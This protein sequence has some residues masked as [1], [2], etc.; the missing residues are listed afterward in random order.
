L[1]ALTTLIASLVM[2]SAPAGSVPVTGGVLGGFEQDGNQTFEGTA[3]GAT[4]DW[5]TLSFD[6][7][8]P[9]VIAVDD[10]LDSG[11]TEGS[12]ELQ[13]SGWAC[14]NGGADPA[15]SDILRAFANPRVG[16][17]I[18]L[19]I[20]FIRK[21]GEDSNGRGDVHVNFEFNQA[22]ADATKCP[23]VRQEGDLLVT[24]DFPGGADAPNIMAWRWDESGGKGQDEGDWDDVGLSASQAK[25]AVNLDAMVDQVG[26][27]S[28]DPLG[29]IGAQRFGEATL[30]LTQALEPEAGAPACISFGSLNVRSRSSGES[31][32]SSLQ[33]KLAP[34]PI[35]FSTCGSIDL[36]KKGNGGELLAGAKFQLWLSADNTFGGDTKVGPVCTT[37]AQGVCDWDDLNPGKYF[38]EETAAPDGYSLDADPVVGPINLG[39]RQTISLDDFVNFK[40]L[41]RLNLSPDATNLVKTDHVFTATLEVKKTA[42]GSYGPAAGETLGIDLSGAV[43]SIVSP[44]TTC[45][46]NAAGQCAITIHSDNP[47]DSFLEVTFDDKVTTIAVD[48][49]DEAV[50]HWV[51]YSIDI[52]PDATNQVGKTH[53]FTVTLK[54]DSGSGPVPVSGA[55]P[56]VTKVSGPGNFSDDS[57]ALAGTNA[58]GQCTVKLTSDVVGTTVVKATYEAVEEA[59]K[60]TF[61][62]TATKHWVD[63]D[64][65]VR[66]NGVNHVGDD[67]EFTVRLTE[68]VNSEP[69][70][71][72]GETVSLD[73]DGPVGS[74]IS[75]AASCET[76]GNGECDVVASSDVTGSGTLTA[77]W[78]REV[79][80]GVITLSDSA[81]KTWIDWDISIA[82]DDK[83]NL[84][85]TDH[86][87][88]VKVR[89]DAGDGEG[90]QPLAGATPDIAIDG[91]GTVKDTDCDEGTDSNG[92]CTATITSAQAGD[93][94]VTATWEAMHASSGVSEDLSASAVKHWVD[95]RIDVQ[96]DAV[97]LVGDN[98]VFTV[99]VT[100]DTGDGFAPLADAD[101][102]L[103]WSGGAGSSITSAV[104]AGATSNAC[105]TDDAGQCK[106]TVKSGTPLT[107]T[108][109]ATY[110][111]VLDSG[112][113]SFSA[114][115]QKRWVNWTLSI[116]PA[117]AEN[118]VGTNHTFVVKVSR[119]DG[120][121][122]GLLPLAG[123][124]PVITL[125]GKG[126]I[127]ANTCS[128]G[129]SA[130]G[131]CT[132]TITSSE[133][134]T[135]TV[136]AAFSATED[137]ASISLSGSGQKL[138]VDYRIAV[139]PKTAVNPVNTTHTFTVTLEKNIGNGWVVA[140]SEKLNL[141]LTGVGSIIGVDLGA[142]GSALAGTCT[143]DAAGT[144]RVTI[145]SPVAGLATLQASYG[146]TVG[147]T[148][149][150]FTDDGAKT[151]EVP[152]VV[153]GAQEL[154]RT[155]NPMLPLLLMAGS[156]LTLAGQAVNAGRRRLLRRV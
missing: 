47:G 17:N 51:D 83:T 125:A 141:G 43:G 86:E 10:T 93:S 153:L 12:K 102:S 117:Q 80:S 129:T 59:T 140:G 34:T 104:P 2:L 123:A 156:S 134:G 120:K 53:T 128:E 45:T 30:D 44:G 65:T 101:V 84:V 37:N 66:P 16:D 130:A 1:L 7:P 56:V 36:I 145:T 91:A 135:S 118:L 132:V 146:A 72:E 22:E 64:L 57:C 106:V 126:S 9:A 14:G 24:Y 114:D 13:P 63:F 48:A 42:N 58:A 122:G 70:G 79:H 67:H 29:L 97:N 151:W 112:T 107:G 121:G 73:W 21:A 4:V 148:S 33:D 11:F 115:G 136:T 25:G 69:V 149:R 52:A 110:S 62:D 99:T 137:Q 23:I 6:A 20:A 28:I 116:T 71:M 60:N 142:V 111:T 103:S 3:A 81:D 152:V 144:C 35:D 77:R 138:W 147:E 88:T 109:T 82:P 38:V 27:A 150:T 113:H 94:T 131:L 76:D 108:L 46:T 127:T 39:F 50:K 154:P 18:F 95:Y 89:Y 87:F 61:S 26:S 155:G 92:T 98:H 41:Y 75:P 31:W 119:D 124:N 90:L 100:E 32:T 49:D 105:V 8:S 19:D 74:S 5:A 68:I 85:G 139:S 133:P 54:R 78:S 143:T 40:W 55:Y 15:K 96:Q